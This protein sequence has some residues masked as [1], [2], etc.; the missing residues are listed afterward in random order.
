MRSV[1]VIWYGRI[2]ISIFS[3][4][5][6]QY[7]VST[8]SRECFA[9]KVFVKSIKS[10]ITRLLASA[11]KQVNSKLLLVFPFF[12]LPEAA[13]L[14]AFKASAVGIVFRICTIGNDK[15]LYIFK[16]PTA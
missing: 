13:S 1:A 2:T 3:D 4:V 14:I 8:F 7:L 5:K 11:Q 10:V 9:K 12:V 16:Q 6:I 15:N